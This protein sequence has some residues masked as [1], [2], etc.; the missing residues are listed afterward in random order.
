MNLKMLNDNG[1]VYSTIL[2]SDIIF[3]KKYNEK[4]IHQIVVSYKNNSRIG[5]RKQ[6][7]RSEVSHSTKK[8]W[9]QKGTGKARA[10]MSSSPLWRGGGRAFPSFPY[11]N[12]S[13][14]INKK[15]Y[16]LS[17][18]ILLSKLV[19]ENRLFVI[20]D[21][22]VNFYKTKILIKK[23]NNMKLKSTLIISEDIN[24]NLILASRNIFN[25]SIIKTFQINPISLIFYKKILFTKKSLKKIQDWLLK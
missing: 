7:N 21:F 12:F 8:P 13:C 17:L 11:E 9:K 4:L 18:C 22:F 23:L 6:K 3:N 19:Y 10:G 20:E 2:V 16:R 15:M 14:K 24:K 1:N 25:I 5:S